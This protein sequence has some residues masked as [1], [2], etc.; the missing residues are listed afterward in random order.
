MVGRL[1]RCTSTDADGSYAK[2]RFL[3]LPLWSLA[4]STSLSLFVVMANQT[5]QVAKSVN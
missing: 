1:T 4:T 3:G 5:I 2:I